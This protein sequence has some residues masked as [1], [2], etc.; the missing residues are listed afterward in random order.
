[1]KKF[2]IIKV[3][4]IIVIIININKNYLSFFMKKY[5]FIF[6]I[7]IAFGCTIENTDPNEKKVNSLIVEII[8][9]NNLPGLSVSVMKNGEIVYSKGFGYADIE[10]KTKIIPSST[11]FRIGSFSKTLT[12]SALMKLVEKNKLNLDESIHTYVPEFPDK[13][14][15]FN[16]RQMGGHLSGIRHYIGN[17]FY[18]NK[19]YKNVID[20]LDIFKDDSLLH[21]PG[22]KYYYSTHTW[23][24]V[25]AAIEKASE[26]PF[27]EYM[28]KNVFEPLGMK[29]TY[30]ETIDLNI[31]DKVTYYKKND[32]GDINIEPEVNNSWKWAGGG[33]ISTTED[34]V[35]F[36]HSHSKSGYLTDESLNILMSPQTTASAGTT[37]YGIGWRKRYG[38]NNE[39]LYG[40]TGGSVGGTT[41]AFIAIDYNVIVVITSNLS[42]ASFGNLPNDIFEIYN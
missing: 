2:V 10:S 11:K 41:Y 7:L 36:L 42:D 4:L 16:L 15:D 23:T 37:N 29:N 31:K 17:E 40:H 32:S 21:E 35:N 13:N 9:S 6:I 39:V 5:T 38:N 22:T 14:W 25:S 27:L 19:N 33:F 26:T 34:I 20:A 18:I 3:V 30:A 8:D 1:M 12:A 24:L 28:Y